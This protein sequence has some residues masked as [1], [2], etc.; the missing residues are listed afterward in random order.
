MS[1]FYG[2]VGWDEELATFYARVWP[3]APLTPADYEPLVS[4]GGRLCEVTEVAKLERCLAERTE[5]DFDPAEIAHWD[6]RLEAD[7]DRYMESLSVEQE[8]NLLFRLR[9]ATDP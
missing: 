8:M 3:E 6:Q 5:I 2:E 9:L 7:R 1:A 4:C